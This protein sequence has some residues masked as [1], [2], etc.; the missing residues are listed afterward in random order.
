MN[1]SALSNFEKGFAQYIDAIKEVGN[2]GSSAVGNRSLTRRF[3]DAIRLMASEDYDCMR[4]VV[5]NDWTISRALRGWEPCEDGI[6]W[7]KS[8]KSCVN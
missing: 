2:Y 5:V 1:K 6:A 3:N 8:L 4:A 7:R